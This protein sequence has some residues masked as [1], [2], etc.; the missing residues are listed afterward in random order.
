MGSTLHG[1][2]YL[3]FTTPMCRWVL[4]APFCRAGNDPLSVS[5]DG[6]QISSCR[7]S[8]PLHGKL[9]RPHSP[10]ALQARERREGLPPSWG[11]HYARLP[12]TE[13]LSVLNPRP[14]Q[15]KTSWS[16]Y[17]WHRWCIP[18]GTHSQRWQVLKFA[19]PQRTQAFQAGCQLWQGAFPAPSSQGSL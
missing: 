19:H 11:D 14:E 18:T 12:R 2:S 1:F 8:H 7:G 6:R 15:T 16:H 9:A 4:L 10:S 5:P 17:S 3:L 13:A